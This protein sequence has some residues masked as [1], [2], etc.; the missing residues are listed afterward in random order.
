MVLSSLIL[1]LLLLT[2]LS[3]RY[4]FVLFKAK[5]MTPIFQLN[6]D[7]SQLEMS[8]PVFLT[9]LWIT[10]QLTSSIKNE[11]MQWQKTAVP[12]Q[13]ISLNTV[14]LSCLITFSLG[15]VLVFILAL[16]NQKSLRK[17]GFRLNDRLGQIRDG[18]VGF[19]LALIPVMALLLLTQAFRTE[20]A[21]H[22][23][24]LLLKA[25]PQFSTISWIIISA[26]LIAPLFEE[27]IYRVLFQGWLE[28]LLPPFAA[29]L[30]S[31]LV[32]SIV[33]GFPDCIPLFPL[34]LILGTLFYYRRSYVSNVITHALFNG[35]NLALALANQ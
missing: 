29:I 13:V 14:I 26:V 5:S 8:L 16:Q 23:L 17:L 30:I 10:H 19:L 27:L 7:R 15:V 28:D 11:W 24:F 22:P 6:T 32:F 1:L 4:W 31:S 33:H 3:T 21:M 20:E 18:S 34:A 25:R 12:S 35:I 9:I 2:L